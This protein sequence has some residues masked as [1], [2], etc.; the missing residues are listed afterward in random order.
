MSMWYLCFPASVFNQMEYNNDKN[1][2]GQEANQL[3]VYKSCPRPPDSVSNILTT[4]SLLP[5]SPSSLAEKKLFNKISCLFLA[6]QDI[7]IHFRALLINVSWEAQLGNKSS[8]TF[9]N[10]SSVI[11]NSVSNVKKIL[12]SCEFFLPHKDVVK[13]PD[14]RTQEFHKLLTF[15]FFSRKCIAYLDHF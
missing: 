12:E 14:Q 15:A 10:L 5:L 11:E 8:E 7:I 9:R 6:P 4:I 3:A 13:G 1:P 2:S